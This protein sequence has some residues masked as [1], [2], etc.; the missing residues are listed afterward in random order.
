MGSLVC[1]RHPFFRLLCIRPYKSSVVGPVMHFAW[2]VCSQPIHKQ[3]TVFIGQTVLD[4]KQC[5]VAL[6]VDVVLI[7]IGNCSV[8]CPTTRGGEM[9]VLAL[10]ELGRVGLQ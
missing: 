2:V 6:T 7:V 8:K 5:L 10:L 1:S 4:D 9:P 3:I